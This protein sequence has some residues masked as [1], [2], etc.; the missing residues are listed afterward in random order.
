MSP[1]TLS[2]W[3]YGMTYAALLVPVESNTDP[4]YRLA[5][6]VDLAN[7]FDA[8]LIGIGAEMWRSPMG[9]F[10][11][12][13]GTSLLIQNEFADVEADLAR[14]E[15]KFR[16][17]AAAVH[18]GIDWRSVLQFPIPQIAAQARA[19]DLIVTSR[20]THHST[21]NYNFAAPGAMALQAGRP[22]IVAPSDATKLELR[23]VLVAWKDTRASRSRRRA[24]ITAA[25]GSD[26]GGGDLRLSGCGSHE[27]SP[28]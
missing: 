25:C 9:D 27:D 10:G 5:F 21:S 24:T 20:S 16:E 22:V 8:K 11:D 2:Q 7:Q 18:N 15:A 23:R 1:S 14:A 17:I 28:R 3:S 4:D 12:G 26:I 19:A 13:L 6:A